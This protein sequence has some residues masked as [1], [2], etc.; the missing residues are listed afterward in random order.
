MKTLKYT[1]IF[2]KTCNLKMIYLVF[3]N[4]LNLKH[5]NLNFQCIIYTL[6]WRNCFSLLWHLH[7]YDV[8]WGSMVL[9]YNRKSS[10][11]IFML[12]CENHYFWIREDYFCGLL[13]CAEMQIG[14]KLKVL[15]ND[16]GGD[17][18]PRNLQIHGIQH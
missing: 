15:R 4:E 11:I 7:S 13:N 3:G 12:K 10:S 1:I 2:V 18:S 14:K 17:L 6:L 16:Y 8:N 9:H 5:L